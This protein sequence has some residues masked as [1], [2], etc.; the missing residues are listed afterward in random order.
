MM[1]IIRRIV[2]LSVILSCSSSVH[3]QLTS[4]QVGWQAELSRLAHNVSGSVT[5]V[6]ENTIRVDDFTYDG[7]GIDVFFYLG[8]E[9]TK[10]AFQS[11]L[12]IGPQLLGT[13]YNGTGPPLV[14]DLPAGQTMQGWNAVSVWCVTAAANFGSGTFAPV[15]SPL[16]GDFNDDGSVDAADYVAWRNGLGG[17]YD[18]SDYDQWRA[19][20]GTTSASAAA[21]NPSPLP[22]SA[23]PEPISVN[24]LVCATVMWVARMVPARR[25]SSRR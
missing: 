1:R 24:L 7:G 2:L 14:I 25:W 12:P 4:P 3:A 16:A 6:D 10:T 21:P 19:H 5:I 17:E 23:V 18:E 22:M 20:F 9:N 11:G 15:A 8:R 13:A